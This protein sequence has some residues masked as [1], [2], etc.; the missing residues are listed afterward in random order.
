MSQTVR[1][2]ARLSDRGSRFVVGIS[3]ASYLIL[4][5]HTPRQVVTRNGRIS[6]VFESSAK[7]REDAERYQRTLDMLVAK[8][9]QHPA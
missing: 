5:S 9:K 6:V 1:L 3:S 4:C 7:I 2:S 8:S